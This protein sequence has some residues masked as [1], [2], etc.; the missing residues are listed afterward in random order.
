M[1]I[2]HRSVNEHEE[3]IRDVDHRHRG[4]NFTT[5][6]GSR[7]H[8]AH[9]LFKRGASKSHEH[10]VFGEGRRTTAEC[11]AGRGGGVVQQLSP[12]T[13]P[14]AELPNSDK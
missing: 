8:N 5:S 14:V 12:G 9:A 3:Y 13:L 7:N 11:N 10:E 4:W 2:P 6:R 1:L